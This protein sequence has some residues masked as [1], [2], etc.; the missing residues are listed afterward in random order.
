MMAACPP[1]ARGMP[2]LLRYSDPPM[3][4]VVEQRHIFG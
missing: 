1:K 3:S 4:A 2:Q